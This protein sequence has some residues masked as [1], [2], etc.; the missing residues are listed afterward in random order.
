[1]ALCQLLLTSGSR[2]L[3][4][5]EFCRSRSDLRFAKVFTSF[6][7]KFYLKAEFLILLLII[8]N[9]WCVLVMLN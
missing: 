2:V 7:S 3:G 6:S 5:P 4:E 1:M 9:A 8:Q